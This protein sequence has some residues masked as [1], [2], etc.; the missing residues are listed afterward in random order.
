[1]KR[2]RAA[3]QRMSKLIDDL[4]ALARVVRGDCARQRVDLSEL[5]AG[6]DAELR[7]EHP[8]RVIE[9]VNEP[10]VI[11]TGDPTL[12]H[13]LLH[14]L[15][16]N[17]WKFTA[18]APDA[19]VEFG[20]G[21]IN[22]EQTYFVRD[23]GVGFDMK[24]ASQLFGVF[25]RLHPLRDFPGNGIG[26]AIVQ[27]AVERHGGRVWAEATPGQG[28]PSVSRWESTMGR[29]RVLSCL[30]TPRAR[31]HGRIK[32][33]TTRTIPSGSPSRRRPRACS[34]STAPAGSRSPTHGSKPCSATTAAS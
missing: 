19:R 23:N 14:N 6:V 4:L 25:Q 32:D 12:L 3:A 7:E 29:R 8:D 18:P 2:V 26:L 17:A 11:V 21:P 5:A 10:G 15:L 34:S 16:S 28:A 31:V 27:R 22:G 9:F 20:R 1:M 33:A 30:A 13:V 24:N